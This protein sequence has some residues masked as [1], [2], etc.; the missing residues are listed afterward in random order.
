MKEFLTGILALTAALIVSLIVLPIG[1]LY[2]LGYSIWLTVTLQDWKA[3]FK[4]LWTLIDGIL[5]AIGH[6]FYYLAEAL[7]IMWNVK[8]EVIEDVITH[9]DNTTFGQKNTTVSY[10]VGKLEH[11]GKLNVFG[12]IL[13]K[14]LNIAFLQKQHA[15]DSYYWTEERKELR[16]KY[17][18]K[19]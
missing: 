7:D 1:F 14:I 5:A 17:F 2:S 8:G 16:K 11:E 19:I 9:E 15:L 10:S 4:Y 3:M 12:R 6:A 13:S 18:E